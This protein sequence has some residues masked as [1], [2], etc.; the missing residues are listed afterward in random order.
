MIRGDERY[1]ATD[2]YGLQIFE[3]E[4]ENEAGSIFGNNG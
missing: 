1:E 2:I 4:A 3:S